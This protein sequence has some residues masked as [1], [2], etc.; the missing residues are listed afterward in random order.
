MHARQNKLSRNA[1]RPNKQQLTF[2]FVANPPIYANPKLEGNNSRRRAVY[3]S[4]NIMHAKKLGN[5]FN[6]CTPSSS[7]SG[8]RTSFGLFA[9][10]HEYQFFCLTC[11]HGPRINLRQESNAR[12]CGEGILFQQ[13]GGHKTFEPVGHAAIGGGWNPVRRLVVAPRN[14]RHFRHTL[15]QKNI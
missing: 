12:R 8:E 2:Q 7:V 6:I 14:F 13:T 10:F 11:A 3:A 15:P 4:M 1:K 5:R 9:N